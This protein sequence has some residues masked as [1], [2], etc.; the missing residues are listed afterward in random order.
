VI[1][2]KTNMHELAFGVTGV[3]AWSGTPENPLDAGR[4]PGGSSSGSAVA[5]ATGAADV[6][7]GT[8][9]GGSIRIPAACCG[10]AG[11]KTSWGRVPLD[12]VR[13]L[14]PSLDTVGPLAM[15]VAGL[16][17]G[18]QLIEPHFALP[19]REPSA[20]LRVGR[21]RP[22][23]DPVVDMAVD[24]ALAASG[25][26]V[27]D[28]GLG[29]WAEATEAAMVLLAA[30]AWEANGALAEALPDKIGPDVLAR[31]YAGRD[32]RPGDR[33]QACALRSAWRERLEA[34]FAT[35][36]LVALPTLAILAPPVADADR[37]ASSRHTLPVNLAGACA[38]ALPVATGTH[39]PAS[40]QL[41]GRPGGDA[42]LLAAAAVLDR[43]GVLWRG[44]ARL[45]AR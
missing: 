36:D 33:T 31:L 23:A 32:L 8:D 1:V 15:D 26:D 6:A 2:G 14:A 40:L 19:Q 34:V 30:E 27:A 16:V 21:F 25:W 9:T 13:P 3:N 22:P 12:G 42:E 37:L 7:L 39:L 35:V 11:L 28:V 5:V 24:G 45:P 38:V 4:V 17:R 41:V 18:M 10:T 44:S 29:G 20:H 43:I